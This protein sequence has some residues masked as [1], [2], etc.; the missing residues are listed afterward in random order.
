MIRLHLY[1]TRTFCDSTW[2]HSTLLPRVSDACL[3]KIYGILVSKA[4]HNFF[5]RPEKKEGEDKLTYILYV[6]LLSNDH[7]QHIQRFKKKKS[8]DFEMFFS[9]LSKKNIAQEEILLP[10][11]NLNYLEFLLM[12]DIA[13]SETLQNSSFTVFKSNWIIFCSNVLP[14]SLPEELVLVLLL[15]NVCLWS[16]PWSVAQF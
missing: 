8:W 9:F 11:Q 10:M 14:L 7:A 3:Q 4:I 6:A 12:T 1:C 15:L 5:S 2:L 16:T 13:E